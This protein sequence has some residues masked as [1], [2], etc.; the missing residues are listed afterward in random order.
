MVKLKVAMAMGFALRNNNTVSCDDF[1]KPKTPALRWKRI[2]MNAS[3]VGKGLSIDTKAHIL[4]LKNWIEAIDQRLRYGN[5]LQLYYKEWFKSSTNQHFFFWLDYG[6]GKE[7]DLEECPRSKLDQQCVKY[8]GPQEREYYEYVVVDGKILCNISR[9]PLH[10]ESPRLKYIFVVSTSKKLYIGEKEKGI[11]HH[12]SFLAGEATLTAGRLLVE[13]GVLK[14]AAV[15]L[16]E[17]GG[18]RGAGTVGVKHF[19]LFLF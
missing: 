11:F 15:D 1:L 12:S 7:V 17:V 4:V 5:N 10:H 18:L 6:D 9:I 8:F 13:D 3:K 14:V 16:V 2:I 19:F